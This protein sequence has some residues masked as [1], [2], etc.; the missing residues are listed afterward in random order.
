MSPTCSS[1]SSRSKG[2]ACLQPNKQNSSHDRCCGA[3]AA[4]LTAARSRAL[5]SL[6]AAPVHAR[7]AAIRGTKL[8]RKNRIDRVG[9]RS[10]FHKTVA[11]PTA[12]QFCSVHGTVPCSTYRERALYSTRR[13]CDAAHD[14]RSTKSGDPSYDSIVNQRTDMLRTRTAQVAC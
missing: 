8:T 2:C 12:I 10:I 3:G 9:N 14:A 5:A 11:W 1:G 13:A 6:P 4:F 7:F